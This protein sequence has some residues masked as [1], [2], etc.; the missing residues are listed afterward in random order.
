MRAPTVLDLYCGQGG[1]GTGY[2]FAGFRVLGVDIAPQ[3][4]YPFDFVQG[5]ALEYLAARG[6][7]FDLVH[8]SPPC[9]GYSRLAA[10]NGTA[11]PRVIP[12]LRRA[13]RASGRPYVIE[14]VLGAP[15]LGAIRLCGE[16]FE[17]GVIRHR[18][19]ECPVRLRA[20]EH[21]EHRG[22]VAGWR[23]GELVAGP[24]VAAYG[25]GG[26]KGSGASWAAA[27]GI[28]WMSKRG[29]REAIPP[30]YTTCIGVQVRR[31]L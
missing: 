21:V 12:A 29:L 14:N 18:Y 23:H 8:A 16:M 4:R 3:E 30:A 27:M 20:P 15:L 25:E 11:H 17:L 24:Y 9:Q 22:R 6:H 19:F 31:A 13:L 26:G 2:A 7:R 28:G 10:V 1:A 5:D